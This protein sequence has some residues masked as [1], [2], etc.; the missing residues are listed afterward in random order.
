MES[1][2]NKEENISLV[3]GRSEKKN[4]KTANLM[5]F[6]QNL[7]RHTGFYGG[8]KQNETEHSAI[9]RKPHSNML[10]CVNQE[11][12]ATSAK[13]RGKEPKNDMKKMRKIGSLS[14]DN[15]DTSEEDDKKGNRYR[16]KMKKKHRLLTIRHKDS[17]NKNVDEDD[18]ELGERATNISPSLNKLPS[19]SFSPDFT[20][21][22]M[23]TALCASSMETVIPDDDI[24]GAKPSINYETTYGDVSR[25]KY[26]GIELS[27]E[28]RYW[29]V[30]VAFICL[31][32]IYRSFLSPV[33]CD[34][35]FQ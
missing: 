17:E 9:R 21:E 29:I 12:I 26:I 27:V 20:E 5:K 2:E 22:N 23:K 19:Q 1:T 25:L 24:D 4:I 32:I 31:L 15:D 7:D 34:T 16:S 10:E 18:I 30:L 6:T 35:Q 13:I 8:S 14:D 33:Q 11:K 3:E 28:L